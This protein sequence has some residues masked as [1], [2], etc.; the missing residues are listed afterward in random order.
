MK[1][2]RKGEY[3]KD[4]DKLNKTY[5][6]Y[7]WVISSGYTGNKN[8]CYFKCVYCD[9][10]HFVDSARK[11]KFHKCK[12]VAWK[13]YTVEEY[14]EIMVEKGWRIYDGFISSKKPCRVQC[15]HCNE[16]RTTE[17]AYNFK[18]IIC[19]CQGNRRLN[20]DFS[21]TV[22]RIKKRLNSYGFELVSEFTSYEDELDVKC[23]KCGGLRH[24]KSIS[25]IHP[26]MKCKHCYK[27][28][29]K[30]C[31][32]DFILTTERFRRY[33]YECAPLGQTF[34]NLDRAIKREKVIERYGSA[35]VI[36]GFNDDI[37]ALLFHHRDPS[38]KGDL[39][40]NKLIMLKNFDEVFAELDQ[41]DLLC[42]N[43]HLIVHNRI[44]TEK[45]AN[46]RFKI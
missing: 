30:Y 21:E 41:C 32:K 25:G 33:C 2:F 19:K 36:C 38:I 5:R 10:E 3:E 13:P 44:N 34:T 22:T 28:K 20:F 40:P 24:L 14:N 9:Q 43:C 37:A 15:I 42:A 16:I 31:G 23:L 8:S 18:N 12:C 27:I 11:I 45:R 7:G 4:Y 6:K 35:C 46:K 29:C 26:Q 39:E 1:G 17:Q